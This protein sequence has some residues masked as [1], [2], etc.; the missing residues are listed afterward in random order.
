[1]E[2]FLP[3]DEATV[4]ARQRGQEVG[5]TPIGPAGGA[6]LRFLA[7]LI[8]A[9]TVV[10]IGTGCGVS[11]ISLMRGM[12]KDGVLTSVDVDHENQRLAKLAY[13]EAGLGSFRTRMIV[14]RALEVLPRL[15]DGAY[16]MV[17]C[18][19]DKTEYPE[20]FSA[21]LRLLRP[22]GV[23]AFDDALGHRRAAEPAYRDPSSEAIREVHH[24]IREDERL[25][26]LLLPVG[27]GLLCAVKRD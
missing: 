22:G 6:A 26:P 5:A 15:T 19:A 4:D 23:V 3:E 16:D 20:Y 12:P 9:R 27:D 10:E 24:L 25:V 8:G 17:F 1:M 13:R 11:G 7:T 14:G 2:E 18:D 21:A